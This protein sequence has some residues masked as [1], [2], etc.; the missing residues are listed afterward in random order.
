MGTLLQLLA[1]C[2]RHYSEQPRVYHTAIAPANS[3]LKRVRGL[4][5]ASL[6]G[7]IAE[8]EE[9][10]PGIIH[11]RAEPPPRVYLPVRNRSEEALAVTSSM[12]VNYARMEVQNQQANGWP[13][14]LRNK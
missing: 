4:S 12:G 3:L 9:P 11:V 13:V 7:E 5:S 1:K 6:L 2:Y 10:A 14:D 8:I